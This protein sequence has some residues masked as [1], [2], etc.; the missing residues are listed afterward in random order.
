MNVH[1]LVIRN[2]APGQCSTGFNTEVELDGQVLNSVSSLNIS[3]DANGLAIV[4]LKMFA[5]LFVELDPA[6]DKTEATKEVI[7]QMTCREKRLTPELETPLSRRFSFLIP[8]VSFGLS[9]LQRCQQP[10]FGC[11]AELLEVSLALD[12]G[13]RGVAQIISKERVKCLGLDAVVAA[14]RRDG[15]V[16][17]FL[18]LFLRQFL[19][20]LIS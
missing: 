15:F 18:D 6:T 17:I 20:L 4:T 11:C 14:A 13:D 1:K 9:V 16:E 5:D 10:C 19:D 12:D 8:D 2:R 7:L 3:I